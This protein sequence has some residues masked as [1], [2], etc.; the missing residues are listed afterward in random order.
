MN[1]RNYKR[2]LFD[3]ILLSIYL[4]DCSLREIRILQKILFKI[5]W[6]HLTTA[7]FIIIILH[8]GLTLYA[9]FIV[10]LICISV[11]ITVSV[12]SKRIRIR[13]RNTER[14]LLVTTFYRISKKSWTLRF[15]LLTRF[16]MFGQGLYLLFFFFLDYS[17]R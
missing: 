16:I 5:L 2:T 11:C 9:L 15:S 14:I 7:K 4:T 3:L 1:T 10:P 8:S 6:L 17:F 13:R 12:I